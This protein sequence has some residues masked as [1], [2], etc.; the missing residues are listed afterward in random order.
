MEHGCL[1]PGRRV[2]DQD[3]LA[4]GTT[5]PHVRAVL[6]MARPP[7]EYAVIE[8]VVAQVFGVTTDEIRQGSRGR[9][10]VAKARQVAMYLAHVIC[11]KSLSDVG[12]LFDRDRTTVS[13]ACNLVED[14]R[15]DRLF[16]QVMELLEGVVGAMTT[17]RALDAAPAQSLYVN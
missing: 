2:S 6:G 5:S 12:R 1:E 9:A 3:T 8:Y 10:H 16:D 7:V 11:R 14:R 15:D 17:P 13:H 4:C